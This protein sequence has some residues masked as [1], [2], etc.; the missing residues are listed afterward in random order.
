MAPDT[1]TT[2]TEKTG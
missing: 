1:C 2:N